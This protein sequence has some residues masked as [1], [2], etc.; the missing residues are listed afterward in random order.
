MTTLT[1]ARLNLVPFTDAH[2]DSLNTMN[3]DPE[4]MRYRL[5]RS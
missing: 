2:L 1:S 4:V 3:S 5:R